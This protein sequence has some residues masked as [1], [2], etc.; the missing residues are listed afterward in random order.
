MRLKRYLDCEDVW[1]MGMCMR[2]YTRTY[3]RVYISTYIKHEML[4]KTN[5]P[6][7]DISRLSVMCPALQ[8]T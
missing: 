1:Y 5:W 4:T 2:T 6:W 7:S 8:C 3:L